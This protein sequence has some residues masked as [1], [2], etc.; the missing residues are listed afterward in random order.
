MHAPP[1]TTA[2]GRATMQ[3]TSYPYRLHSI[4]P[5]DLPLARNISSVF[6]EVLHLLFIE[7]RKTTLG[8]TVETLQ[9]QGSDNVMR[10]VYG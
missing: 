8:M 5:T 2:K 9:G 6:H 1:A 4:W 10:K 3:T 7:Q